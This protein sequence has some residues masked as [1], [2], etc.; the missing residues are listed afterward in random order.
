[1]R[2][3]RVAILTL[4]A[5]DRSAA[6]AAELTVGLRRVEQDG[7]GLTESMIHDLTAQ[8]TV[9]GVAEFIAECKRH[10]ETGLVQE[11]LTAFVGSASR[12]SLD[13]ALL[14]FELLRF[15]CDSS[16]RRFSAP[17]CSPRPSRR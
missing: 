16:A 2:P 8:R 17:W 11:T 12:V 14:Y 5:V 4:A 15:Q 10:G 9:P 6:E 3:P 13:K 7:S 1:M